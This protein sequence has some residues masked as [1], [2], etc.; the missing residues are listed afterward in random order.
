VRTGCVELGLLGAITFFV[1]TAWLAKLFVVFADD[2]EA[3]HAYTKFVDSGRKVLVRI[4]DHRNGE[5]GP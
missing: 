1:V 5:F 3:Q 4:R 2:W